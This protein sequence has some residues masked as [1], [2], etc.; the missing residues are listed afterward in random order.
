MIGSHLS[1]LQLISNNSSLLKAFFE[2]YESAVGEI[3]GGFLQ[4]VSKMISVRFV[5]NDIYMMNCRLLIISFFRDD[6]D[7]NNGPLVEKLT[8]DIFQRIQGNYDKMFM[9]LLS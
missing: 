5:I 4:S 7:L 3:K 9:F 2:I 6:Q 1:G 8:F